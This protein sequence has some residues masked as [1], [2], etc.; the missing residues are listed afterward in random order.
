[1]P[2]SASPAVASFLEELPAERR[3]ELERVRETV[4]RHLPSG[5]EEALSKGMIVYQVPLQRYSDTYN[6]YPLWYAALAAQKN[7]LTLHLMN[8]YG[9]RAETLREGFRAAGKRLDMGKACIRFQRADDLALDAI[10]AV[11]AS[12]PLDEWVGIA[13]AARRR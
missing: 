9:P 3:A 10:A 6:G 4:R 1:M 2:P 11:V 13:Q 7:Y 8:A 5:F 12:T